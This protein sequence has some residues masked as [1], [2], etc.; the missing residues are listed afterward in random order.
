M[1]FLLLALHRAVFTN[2]NCWK[3]VLYTIKYIA[4]V[5]LPSRLRRKQR[6]ETKPNPRHRVRPCVCTQIAKLSFQIIIVTLRKLRNSAELCRSALPY[7]M[8]PRQQTPHNKNTGTAAAVYTY[9]EVSRRLSANTFAREINSWPNFRSLW[10]AKR[11]GQHN[12]SNYFHFV[13]STGKTLV[14]SFDSSYILQIILILEVE[15]YV[16]SVVTAE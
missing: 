1:W 9:M 12:M 11:S 3:G 6:C 7:N 8:N 10:T 15:I 2:N 16:Q 4:V 13:Q 14:T 5:I